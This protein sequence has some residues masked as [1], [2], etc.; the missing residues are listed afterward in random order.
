MLLV[1]FRKVDEDYPLVRVELL[2]QSGAP[3][4]IQKRWMWFAP[5]KISVRR[6]VKKEGQCRVYDT[7]VYEYTTPLSNPNLAMVWIA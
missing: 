7:L 2:A 5:F 3:R 4:N 6:V 1:T